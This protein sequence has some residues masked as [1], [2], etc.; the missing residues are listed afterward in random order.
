[1]ITSRTLTFIIAEICLGI[2]VISRLAY[3]QIF[4]F[5]HY[6]LLS[7]KNRLV[8]RHILPSRGKILCSEGEVVACN[9]FSYSAFLDSAGM[10]EAE[11]CE[12]ISKIEKERGIRIEEKHPD[13]D[14]RNNKLILLQKNIDWE[15]LSWYYVTSIKYPSILIEKTESR[16]Y[17]YPHEM[18]HVVGYTS[19]PKKEDFDRTKNIALLLPMAKIGKTGI[20]KECDQVLFGKIGMHLTEVNSKR[21]FVRIVDCTNG[22]PGEDVRLTINLDL[23]RE[24][25]RLLSEHKSGSCIVMDVNTGAILA[26]VSY[27]GY[28]INVFTKKID[29][30]EL[31]ELYG[32][33]YKPMINKVIS[34]VYAPGSVFKIITALA[35]L[36]YGIIN[37][38]TCFH[39]SGVH[40]IGSYKFHCWKWKY[41]GHGSVDIVKAIAESCDIYF[42]NIATLINPDKIA[43][44]ANDFGLG[45]PTGIDMPHEKSGLIPT[46]AWKKSKKKQSWTKGDSLN[47]SIG[48]GFTLA[49]PLQI[50]RMIS[51]LVNGLRPV[52]P[53]ILSKT[54]NEVGK[55]LD[56][57]REHVDI[58]VDSMDAVV[59]S[60]TG[61]ARNSSIDDDEFM[62][63]GKTG[64][65]QVCQITEE[66]RRQ[67]MTVSD[68]YWLKE[69]SVFAGYAPADNPRFVV[70]VLIEH[71]GGGAKVAA[72]IAR[73]VLLAAKR[74]VVNR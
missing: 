60:S 54:N 71:G 74:Y 37:E 10:S 66:Q 55:R 39:C 35:G 57:K 44:V 59:N 61:T 49:T 58:I 68:D 70:V 17:L 6:R 29:S 50:A 42:Y 19:S 64:S 34:G 41:D 12:I 4:K 36:H 38:N 52:I 51:I 53:H 47:M 67:G 14:K 11:K 65:S 5:A 28:D 18:S 48:Q 25:Y 26:F 15:T 46:R 56:Y 63:G 43:K 31:N 21:E 3:L 9:K 72:P 40:N 7:D 2:A 22:V 13:Q 24:V 8:T 45:L 20:E 30:K 23:Q 27:P 69:H 62:M 16:K 1:V 73:N 32:N 33:P